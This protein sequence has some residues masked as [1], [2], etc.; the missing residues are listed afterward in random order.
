MNGREGLVGHPPIVTF[1]G[2]RDNGQ[3]TSEGACEWQDGASRP[4]LC[5]VWRCEPP[6]L[7][8]G[9]ATRAAEPIAGAPADP[10]SG[11]PLPATSFWNLGFWRSGSKLG[12]ILSQA[13]ER[14]TGF[15]ERLEL[16]ERLLRLAHQD[17]D[18]RELVLNVGAL[19]RVF[20]EGPQ[21]DAAIPSRI[22]SSFRPR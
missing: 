22:A 1:N 12:S 9:V 4:T 19:H 8:P 16:V 5:W 2:T 3:R 15:S 20:R 6:A 21:R 11:H 18:S 17:V 13:G 14:S 7:R 10:E